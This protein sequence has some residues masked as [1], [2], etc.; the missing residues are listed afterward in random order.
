MPDGRRRYSPRSP[1]N[2]PCWPSVP[3]G[4]A[5]RWGSSSAPWPCRSS[6]MP[7]PRWC[8]CG[9][10]RKGTSRPHGVVRSGGPVVV[11]VKLESPAEE[12]ITFAFEDAARRSVSVRAVH[13]WNMPPALTSAACGHRTSAAGGHYRREDGR[14]EPSPARRGVSGTRPCRSSVTSWSGRPRADSSRLRQAGRCWSWAGAPGAPDSAMRIGAA[15]QAAMHHADLPV[16]VVPKK[17]HEARAEDAM[18]ATPGAV[19]FSRTLIT[20]CAARVP[21][22]LRVRSQPSVP[23]PMK[24]PDVPTA[25]GR[26]SL[27]PG[28]EGPGPPRH[29][30]CRAGETR[31]YPAGSPFPR[32]VIVTEAKEGEQVAIMHADVG[33]QIIVES[34]TIGGPRRDGEIIGIHHAGRH[35]ALRREVVGFRPRDPRL[36][37][38]RRPHPASRSPHARRGRLIVAGGDRTAPGTGT[39]APA[40]GPPQPGAMVPKATP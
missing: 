20:R 36:P 18:T 28:A 24:R 38:A 2:R 9:P 14:A 27:T 39:L 8:W 4:S 40:Q 15:T 22:L 30:A 6:L 17:D 19:R 7:S 10:A 25:V 16:A 26:C 31:Q 32:P 5:R 29:P 13:G 11:G 21:P 35:S 37:R 3:A 33:D 1:K 12:A 34:Q 23:P